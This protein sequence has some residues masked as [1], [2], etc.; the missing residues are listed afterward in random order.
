MYLIISNIISLFQYIFIV[1]LIFTDLYINSGKTI[2]RYAKKSLNYIKKRNKLIYHNNRLR[3]GNFENF[4]VQLNNINDRIDDFNKIL[5]P[6]SNYIKEFEIITILGIFINIFLVVNFEYF[7][8]PFLY[9]SI[10]YIIYITDHVKT[11]R[12]IKRTKLYKQI[13]SDLDFLAFSK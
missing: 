1:P 10:L 9:L 2:Y 3:I 6:F 12:N 5:T 8:I 7:L 13:E 4:K 11:N